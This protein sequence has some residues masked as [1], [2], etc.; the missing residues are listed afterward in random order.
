MKFTDFEEL[1]EALKKMG[2][3]WDNG[4][5]TPIE[6]TI[7]KDVK[8]DKNLILGNCGIYKLD[9]KKGVVTRLT[10]NICDKNFQDFFR[11]K[12]KEEKERKRKRIREMIS[13]KEFYNKEFIEELH[14]YH[15]S[16]CRAIK[17]AKRQSR[18][19]RYYGSSR[20]T[21]F[22]KYSI[23]ENNR[24]LLEN[25]NQKLYPC[26]YC[27]GN[28]GADRDKYD[29]FDIRE[30][31]KWPGQ[32][33]GE[34]ELECTYKPNLYPEDWKEISKKLKKAKNYTCQKCGT[35]PK[36]KQDIHCHHLNHLKHDNRNINLQVLC[37]KCHEFFHPHMRK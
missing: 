14:R 13:K 36:K 37:R 9:E 2:V 6:V 7:G 23:I 16:N 25:E 28:L 24:S 10:L 27:L 5:T 35:I 33:Q 29:K 20:W 32:V 12:K 4:E 26:K 17:K 19:D 11:K 18:K 15:F 31:L 30:A 1:G 8:L 22:F 21:G 34:Y 3:S